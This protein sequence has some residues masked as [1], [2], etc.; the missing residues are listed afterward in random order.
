MHLLDDAS[1]DSTG[2]SKDHELRTAP[3][4]T[5]DAYKAAGFEAHKSQYGVLGRLIQT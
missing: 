3:V 5:R 4:F 2:R 1:L